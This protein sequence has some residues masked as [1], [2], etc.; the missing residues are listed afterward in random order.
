MRVYMYVYCYVFMKEAK[1][2]NVYIDTQICIPLSTE[3]MYE[4]YVCIS[5]C[6]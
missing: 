2:T 3:C 4:C 6:M 1:F 5:V